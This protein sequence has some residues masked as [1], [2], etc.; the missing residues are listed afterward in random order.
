MGPKT[1]VEL[2]LPRPGRPGE[3]FIRLRSSAP[4]K[5]KILDSRF[6]GQRVGGGGVCTVSLLALYRGRLFWFWFKFNLICENV[7]ILFLTE[8]EI[9][10]V[11]K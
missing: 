2:T 1:S 6:P 11:C 3:D 10:E 8:R 4:D 9:F 5:L 7:E